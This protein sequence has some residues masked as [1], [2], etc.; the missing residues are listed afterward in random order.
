MLA[1]R[2]NS[3]NLGSPS[4]DR[5]IKD[6]EHEKYNTM[7]KWTVIL[8]AMLRTLSVQA[9]YRTEESRIRALAEL[10]NAP[11][12]RSENEQIVSIGAGELKTIYFDALMYE[13]KP[14]RV[15]AWLGIPEEASSS[16]SLIH[17]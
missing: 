9:D 7:I 13:G 6:G 4:G 16:L 14:T 12:V 2:E 3:T 1:I 15:Y 17:I 11:V 10:T 5:A 8:T